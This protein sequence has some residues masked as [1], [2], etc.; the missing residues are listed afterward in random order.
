MELSDIGV[1]AASLRGAKPEGAPAR[2][3]PEAAADLDAA[4]RTTWGDRYIERTA[5]H[6]ALGRRFF[7]DK[8]PNN[9][10]HVGLIHLILPGARIIDVRRH[11]MAACFSTFKQRF[12][13]GQAFS[14]DLGD[15]GRYYRDYVDLMAHFDEVLP[16]R[17]HRVIYEDLVDDAE[18]EIRR[19]LDHCGLPFEAACLKFYDNPRAVRTVSSEQVRQPIFREG[20]DQWRHYQSWLGPLEDALGPALTTWRAPSP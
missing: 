16:G 13:Q 1:I 8:M 20:L 14:Y 17:V 11:P 18:R 12:A 6:R 2:R 9:F 10:Q 3:Y 4:A 15:L 19:L 5:I 7:V